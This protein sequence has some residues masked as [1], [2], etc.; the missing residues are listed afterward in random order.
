MPRSGLR[1]VIPFALISL[2]CALLVL[3]GRE[4]W[5]PVFQLDSRLKDIRLTLTSPPPP[6]GRVAIVAIDN[7]SIKEIGRWP[8][9]RRVT[10][11]LIRKTASLSPRVIALDMLF[12]EPETPEGDR[13]LSNAI[14]EAG[15]VILGYF[16]RHEAQPVTAAMRELLR[17]TAVSDISIAPGTDSIPVTGF[18]HV[19]TTIEAIAPSGVDAAF[20]NQIPDG[21]G[22]YRRSLLTIL[23]DGDLYA[24]LALKGVALHQGE[25]I[26]VALDRR[27]ITRLTAGRIQLP[28]H[29]DGTMSIAWYGPGGRILTISAADVIAGRCDPSAL[30]DRLVFIGFTEKG[31]YDLRATPLDPAFPGVEIHATVASNI[32]SGRFIDDSPLIRRMETGLI[33]LIPLSLAGFLT[34]TRSS[35]QG[36]IVALLAAASYSA[37]NLFLFQRHLIDLSPGFP[38]A[39]LTLSFVGC[40]IYRNLVVQKEGRYLQKAFSSYVSPELV[41]ELVKNPERL[42]LGGEKRTITVLFSDIRGFTTLSETL[43]PDTLVTL[44]NRYLTPMTRLV[45][46]EKGMLDKYIGDAIMAVYNAPLPIEL[47]ADHACRTALAM[48]EALAQLNREFREEGHPTLAIGIGIHTGEAVV[49]NMGAENRFDYT[50]IGDTVN[51]ASRLEG[52][53]KLYGVSI[54][55]SEATRASLSTPFHTRELDLVRVKGKREPVAIHELRRDAYPE[56]E[57]YRRALRLYRQGA[58]GEAL[59]L[60][61]TLPDDTVVSLYRKRCG[62]ML[63]APPGEGWDGVYTAREK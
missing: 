36:G 4:G 54:I 57:V 51:L 14:A 61:G 10:A 37:L 32:L 9:P 40:E 63:A 53:S 41:A 39:S 58:F 48:G 3:G 25:G 33:I 5:P 50:A 49:G 30:R 55:I 1:V 27:G 19:D 12:S 56:E 47:H 44:L 42:R 2:F 21:D 35:W 26:H 34:L 59:R 20:F 62:E 43:P 18:P 8:W 29:P 22:L 7:R 45:M 31:I 38:L 6:D 17:G 11:E 46:S 60:F 16:F 15:N 52:L 24:S 13:D 28:V 23:H